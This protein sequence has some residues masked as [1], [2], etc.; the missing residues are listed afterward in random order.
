MN[1]VEL[2]LRLVVLLARLA[3][4]SGNATVL[5]SG[6]LVMAKR[7]VAPVKFV[8]VCGELLTVVFVD[9]ALPLSPSEVTPWG[10]M[11]LTVTVYE[12]VVGVPGEQVAGELMT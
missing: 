7:G 3:V 2:T 8:S 6:D 11:E 9:V 5:P 4:A 1:C 12:S 10:T